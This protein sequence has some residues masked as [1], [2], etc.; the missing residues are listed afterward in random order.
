MTPVVT[1]WERFVRLATFYA[2]VAIEV[3]RH[4]LTPTE[5]FYSKTCKPARP[6][7]FILLCGM[8]LSV[9]AMRSAIGWSEEKLDKGIGGFSG[10]HLHS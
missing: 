7:L 1:L 3:S 5:F 10:F 9:T 8:V 6:H 4:V 2:Y